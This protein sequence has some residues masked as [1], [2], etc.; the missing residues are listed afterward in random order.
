MDRF[1]AVLMVGFAEW[2]HLKIA[3][4][5]LPVSVANDVVSV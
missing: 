5:L 4:F 2:D 3:R 1:R